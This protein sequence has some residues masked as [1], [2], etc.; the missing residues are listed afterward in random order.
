[1][2]RPGAAT[3]IGAQTLFDAQKRERPIATCSLSTQRWGQAYISE[4]SYRGRR[5]KTENS[6]PVDVHEDIRRRVDTMK[7]EVDELQI[8]ASRE[9]TPSYKK[10]EVLIP[11]I[12]SAAAFLF[13]VWSSVQTEGRIQR[14]D[15]HA[16]RA[17]LR[18]LIQRLQSLPKE[19]IDIAQAYPS[20]AATRNFLGGQ[21]TGETGVLGQQAA[22]L[23]EQ[24]EGK[25]SASEYLATSVALNEV[26]QPERAEQL[27]ANGLPKMNDA[28]GEAMLLRQIANIRFQ[29]RDLGGGRD[30]YRR[31]LRVFEKYPGANPT[32]VAET[33][34]YTESFWATSEFYQR[35]C[36]DAWQHVRLAE[37]HLVELAPTD[38][39]KS[40]TQVT[41]D[42]V[43]KGC[44]P[45]PS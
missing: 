21:I 33:Q 40:H 30:A 35:Q 16:A 41:N 39:A 29:F 37:S 28:L 42:L 8:Q 1:M 45:A 7:Q 5:V 2:P 24:L 15:Q 27:L 6:P 22:E 17:E 34:A 44:G 31:A 11:I 3:T 13:T 32:F 12:V 20:D 43:T 10:P 26:G 25:V 9:R 4:A 23:I 19:R 38:P 36:S 18:G 14:Q